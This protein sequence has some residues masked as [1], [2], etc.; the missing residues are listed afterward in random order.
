ML[1]TGGFRPSLQR[2]SVCE[3]EADPLNSTI[4]PRKNSEMNFPSER[5]KSNP[6][7]SGFIDESP[8]M[9]PISAGGK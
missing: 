9:G 7:I 4:N 5:A 1:N 2:R 8:Y 6:N 3:S